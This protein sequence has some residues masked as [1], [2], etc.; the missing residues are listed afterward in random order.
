MFK[1]YFISI[2]ITLAL[3]VLIYSLF[4]S[5]IIYDGNRREFYSFYVI[6]S[7]IFILIGI[8]L[9]YLKEKLQ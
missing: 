4:K 7:L 6:L 1:K 2:F 3:L 9:S 5:E 8:V